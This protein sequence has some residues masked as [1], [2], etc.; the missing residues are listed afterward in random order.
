MIQDERKWLIDNYPEKY[1]T[2][3]NDSVPTKR[4]R[5][6]EAY[7]AFDSLTFIEQEIE[8]VILELKGNEQQMASI[9]EK[10]Q[11]HGKTLEQAVRD[12]AHWIVNYKLEHGTLKIPKAA[13]KKAVKPTNIDIQQ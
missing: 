11:Q 2:A 9:R 4:S 3:L 13:R 7:L 10:A 1:F 6:A 8:K 5:Q 12:D